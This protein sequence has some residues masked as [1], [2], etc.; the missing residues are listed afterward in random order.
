M[1]EYTDVKQRR[2][3]VIQTVRD[4]NTAKKPK[5][6]REAAEREIV[7]ELFKIFQLKA[8]VK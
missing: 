1:S 6:C 5:E 3:K 8:A 2:H 7:E 4:N